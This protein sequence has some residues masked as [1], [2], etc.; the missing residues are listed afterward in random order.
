MMKTILQMS[1]LCLQSAT[2]IQNRSLKGRR[3]LHLLSLARVESEG[4]D[5][6][7]ESKICDFEGPVWWGRNLRESSVEGQRRGSCGRGGACP[8]FEESGGKKKKAMA[9]LEAVGMNKMLKEWP[10]WILKKAKTCTHY[11]FIPLIIIIGMNTD[12]KPQLSQLLSP[13]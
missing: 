4:D 3:K 2:E 9:K 1:R 7:R 6:E 5:K 8:R 11:G 12:P 13:V 10:T